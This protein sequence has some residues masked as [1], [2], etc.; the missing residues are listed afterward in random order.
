MGW[1]ISEVEGAGVLFPINKKVISP[2][3][4]FLYFQIPSSKFGYLEGQGFLMLIN[5]QVQD[6]GMGK[7]PNGRGFP[8]SEDQVLVFRLQV[9]GLA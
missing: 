3:P 7:F 4:R 8:I 5:G 2:Q 1:T 9:S 6:T